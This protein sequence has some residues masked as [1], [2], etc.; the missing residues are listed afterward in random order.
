MSARA[1]NHRALGALPLQL[2]AKILAHHRATDDFGELISESALSLLEAG[3]EDTFDKIFSR[4]R[5]RC[6][7]FT[8]DLAHYSGPIDGNVID[9]KE[10]EE[11]AERV[12]RKQLRARLEADLRVSKRQAQRIIKL[13]L[14]QAA[15]QADLFAF[16][17][18]ENGVAA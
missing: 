18:D 4:A 10:E 13:K 7:R 12:S 8:Q 5:S 14:E 11:A 3:S 2:Q 9:K 15:V 16:A 1:L 6:R 17:G